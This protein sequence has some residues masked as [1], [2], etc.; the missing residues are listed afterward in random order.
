MRFAAQTLVLMIASAAVVAEPAVKIPKDTF[1]FGKVVQNQT[2]THSF[3]IKSTGSDTLRITEVVPGC[4]CTQMPLLDSVLGPGDSTRLDI[5]FTT[6]SFVGHV[7]K[8]PYIMTNAP[9]SKAGM[10]I[11]AEILTDPESAVPVVIRPPK[12]DVSQFTAQP[13]RRATFQV[14]N[15]SAQ[16]LEVHLLDTAFKSFDVE[17]PARI[18]AGVTIEGAVIVKKDRVATAFKESFTFEVVGADARDIYTLPI[19]RM[20]YVKDSVTALSAP[21]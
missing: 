16:E 6:R 13:R 7:N 21:Q 15:K 3:W 18:K 5:T 14:V 1:D 12:L 20:Y 8:R 10:S 9:T 19:D 2:T 17:L 4:G 11:F